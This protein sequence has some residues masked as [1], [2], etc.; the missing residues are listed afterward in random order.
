M[1]LLEYLEE[2]A[3]R[4]QVGVDLLQADFEEAHPTG[5]VIL[6][7]IAESHRY[8]A[9]ALWNTCYYLA[10][11]NTRRAADMLVSAA[12]HHYELCFYFHTLAPMFAGLYDFEAWVADLKE[13]ATPEARELASDVFEAL[14]RLVLAWR[15]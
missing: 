4:A 10:E 14:D 3:A 2:H 9:H 7:A 1:T 6:D 11:G 13:K 8:A 15:A 12:T 5:R